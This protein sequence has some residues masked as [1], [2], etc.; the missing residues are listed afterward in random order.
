M[1]TNP[2]YSVPRSFVRW[3]RGLKSRMEASAITGA[4]A[5]LGTSECPLQTGEQTSYSQHNE[6]RILS[7]IF[8][9]RS[10]GTALEVGGFDGVTFSNT[11]FFE[12][13]GWR[14]FIVEPMPEF[15]RKIRSNRKAT[16]FECAA[17]SQQGTASFTVAKGVEALSTLNPTGNQLKN[18]QYH[19]AV[20]EQIEVPVRTLDDIL[21]SA[22]IPKLDFVTID[23]E[24]HEPDAIAGFTLSR[25]NPEIV[26]VEDGSL[27]LDLTVRSLMRKKGYRRFMTTGWNDWYA[28]ESDTRV[29]TAGTVWRDGCR[30][31]LSQ[32]LAILE[33]IGA[34]LSASGTP[35][36]VR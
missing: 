36:D 26:I 4:V 35:P 25:W 32:A 1:L 21:E 14:T 31:R 7:S 10:D 5:A 11:Y 2:I 22:A 30:A 3:L 34:R 33:K 9:D 29:I 27:G 24:G 17:G 8:G 6:D 18:M 19:G 20:L 28:P 12:Q 15:A 23:V 16:L 13:K